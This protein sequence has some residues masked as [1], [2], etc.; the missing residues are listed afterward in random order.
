[1]ARRVVVAGTRFGRVYLS[2]FRGGSFDFELAG[3]LARG[4]ERSLACARHYGVPL[5]REPEELPEDIDIVCVVVGTAVNGGDGC[6]IAQRL[7]RRGISVL[8]EHP[9]HPDELAACLRTAKEAGVAYRV[10]AHF[11]HLRPVRRFVALAE[12][13]RAR[14]PVL[15]V[16]ALA[17]M[18]TLYTL[19]DIIGRLLGGLRPSAFEA[20]PAPSERLVALAKTPQPFRGLHGVIAGVPVSLRIQNEI[21]PAEPDNYTHFFHRIAI[22]TEA[23]TLTLINTHG[24]VVW[25]PRAHMPADSQNRV[26]YEASPADHLDFP[27]CTGIGAGEAPSFREILAKTWPEGIRQALEEFGRAVDIREDPLAAGQYHLALANLWRDVTTRIAPVRIMRGT[28]PDILPA[29][30]IAAAAERRPIKT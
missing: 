6:E 10:N 15:F 21:D 4:S 3:I 12:A 20:A 7:M 22:G 25:S 24:P 8:Q 13:L 23:G 14:Q 29:E 2:A 5:F 30:A 28:A 11:A 9:L 18:Q 16:D 1:L 17:S 27:T 26:F 19:L